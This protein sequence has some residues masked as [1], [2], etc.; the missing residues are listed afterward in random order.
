MM[1]VKSAILMLLFLSLLHIHTVIA[2]QWGLVREPDGETDINNLYF[3]DTQ[4]GWGV[5]D[6]GIILSTED[7]G[8]FWHALD[9]K[10]GRSF[11][12]VFFLNKAVGWVVG[13]RGTIMKTTDGG[14]TWHQH[15][16]GTRNR[17]YQIRFAS[18][19]VGWIVGDKG[20][21]LHTTDG[22]ERWE[23]Q[24]RGTNQQLCDLAVLDAQRV[25]VAGKFGT[26]LYTDNGGRKWQVRSLDENYQFTSIAFVTEK[27]GFLVGYSGLLLETQ[28]GTQWNKVNLKTNLDL[29]DVHFADVQN[30]C[31]VGVSGRIWRTANGT[32][33]RVDKSGMPLQND[34]NAVY[35]L[36]PQL[37]YA[38]GVSGLIVK[39]APD[40]PITAVSALD[41]ETYRMP[42][43]Q[44]RRRQP[45]PPLSLV[46]NRSNFL[47]DGT[48]NERPTPNEW[49]S[50][51]SRAYAYWRLGRK[52]EA[53][54]VWEQLRSLVAA[55]EIYGIDTFFRFLRAYDA[56]QGVF[57]ATL[58]YF[59]ATIERSGE[60]ET[61]PHLWLF[62]GYCEYHLGKINKAKSTWQKFPSGHNPSQRDWQR[63]TRSVN[64]LARKLAEVDSLR[65]A[66][67]KDQQRSDAHD[68]MSDQYDV[69]KACFEMNLLQVA[70]P[71]L[72][73]ILENGVEN[74]IAS[75][76]QYLLA[77]CYYYQMRPHEKVIEAYQAVVDRFPDS[78]W[79]DDAAY[80]IVRCLMRTYKGITPSIPRAIVLYRWLSENH[81][82]S[83]L[84]D[85]MLYEI[86][87]AAHRRQQKLDLKLTEYPEGDMA[88]QALYFLAR[89]YERERKIDE[90]QS[91]MRVYDSRFPS[92]AKA[93]YSSASKGQQKRMVNI[94]QQPIVMFLAE[95]NHL[96]RALLLR[97]NPRQNV[98][99]FTQIPLDTDIHGQKFA[100]LYSTTNIGMLLSE[101]GRIVDL[102]LERFVRIKRAELAEIVKHLGGS[103]AALNRL[104]GTQ[105][106]VEKAET[107]KT[108]F[109]QLIPRQVVLNRSRNIKALLPT[110]IQLMRIERNVALRD[111]FALWNFAVSPHTSYQVVAWDKLSSQMTTVRTSPKTEPQ[112]KPLGRAE[113]MQ[114]RSKPAKE[115]KVKRTEKTGQI[116]SLEPNI[117]GDAANH[118]VASLPLPPI[119]RS[120]I[121]LEITIQ[122]WVAQSGVVSGMA[123]VTNV[124]DAEFRAVATDYLSQIR[125]KP[126]TN[127]LSLSG[128]ITIRS[129]SR[130]RL[131]EKQR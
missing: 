108:L 87:L 44:T 1:K 65:K 15:Q 33:W 51:I 100:S 52:A 35:L 12:G 56:G 47:G 114:K 95:G 125:F 27:R 58:S 86:S 9:T 6:F 117:Q 80:M 82:A 23:V 101:M 88:E 11:Y 45:S 118:P 28:D 30:G 10:I 72:K 43:R 54:D 81:P 71:I 119:Y 16:S 4:H 83:P 63:R 123:F 126:F 120:Q 61:N 69:A 8:R 77:R 74:E 68:I 49:H 19:D 25:Y 20:T 105:A 131:G 96:R 76:A 106:D 2:A 91:V 60:A 14:K 62:K 38:S 115:Q 107:L 122:F 59:E 3:V 110:V 31:I 46:F 111:L 37:A 104:I 24:E 53:Q 29:M 5:G 79:S 102:R 57:D 50:Q 70:I 93:L 129:Q 40:L 85:D 112:T 92:K 121:P 97:V 21:I 84:R 17:L 109:S 124:S 128:Q 42:Q 7:G 78:M 99:S 66:Y 48:L 55:G 89:V 36:N 103:S 67:Q 127:R 90:F 41:T 98:I 130:H 64:G 34:L 22:G 75:K 13:S 18:P 94:A 116:S 39:Y 26:L 32:D 113:S 73:E